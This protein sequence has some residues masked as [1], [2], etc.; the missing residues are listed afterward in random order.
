MQVLNEKL[1]TKWQDRTRGGY[2]YIIDHIGPGGIFPIHGTVKNRFGKFD[3]SWTSDGRWFACGDESTLDL[4]EVP[5]ETSSEW[6][7]FDAKIDEVPFLHMHDLIEIK[8][9]IYEDYFNTVTRLAGSVYWDDARDPIVA[10]RLV[11][12]A[13]VKV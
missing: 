3:C 4:I 1:V 2:E 6:I 11:K 13:G 7:K 5:E 10:Y 12:K 9:E 8:T